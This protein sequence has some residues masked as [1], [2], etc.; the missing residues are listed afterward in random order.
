[1]TFSLKQ[2]RSP[3]YDGAYAGVATDTFSVQPAI[4]DLVVVVGGGFN[5]SALLAVSDNQGHTY[6]LIQPSAADSQVCIA[7]AVVTASSGSFTVTVN[8]SSR[9]SSAQISLWSGQHATPLDVSSV[10]GTPAPSVTTTAAGDL[11]IT[12]AGANNGGNTFT[13]P[14]GFTTMGQVNGANLDFSSAYKIGGS[15]G[16]E[17]AT[18][19]RDKA[20]IAAFK[21]AA[22]VTP[23]LSVGNATC[24]NL[25]G[26]VN[27]RVTLSS[28]NA[29]NTTFTIN[30]A[31]VTAIAGP[32]YTAITGG[33]GTIPAGS[34]YVDI[35]VTIQP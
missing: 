29:A 35:P 16:A 20:I 25:D 17:T 5:S 33:T 22:T 23:T 7:Y 11:I 26:T 14:S 32:D 9:G 28:A 12:V 1:M 30:T 2:A 18:W 27:V 15:A 8:T 34:L 19:N 6:T 4:G 24:T 31:D 10:T 21:T 3:V 13:T